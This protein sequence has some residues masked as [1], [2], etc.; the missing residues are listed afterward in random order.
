MLAFLAA[1]VFFVELVARP[2]TAVNLNV[3]GL[4]LI[5]LH[6]CVGDVIGLWR[7]RRAP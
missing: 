6:L 7:T 3:L 5:A 1:V 2:H 4:F